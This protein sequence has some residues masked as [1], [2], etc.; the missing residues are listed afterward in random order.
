MAAQQNPGQPIAFESY[1]SPRLRAADLHLNLTRATRPE[2]LAFA[3]LALAQLA[4]AP[5]ALAQFAFAQLA[6][7]QLACA[8]LALALS[9]YLAI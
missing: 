1:M 8:R 4:F 9:S 7:A 6:L 5:S 3:Q 2:Q